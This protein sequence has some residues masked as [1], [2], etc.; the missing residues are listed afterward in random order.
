[1]FPAINSKAPSAGIGILKPRCPVSS[2]MSLIFTLI[3]LVE[4]L[5]R[6][7]LRTTVVVLAGQVYT[8]MKEFALALLPF[9]ILFLNVLGIF[10]PTSS[11]KAQT[12]TSA[13]DADEIACISATV[14]LGN[15]A[16]NDSFGPMETASARDDD[17]VPASKQT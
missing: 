3:W 11:N 6:L 1:M 4:M 10:Y 12:I 5:Q 13:V 8:V 9:L 2:P 16:I 7:M 17:A 14:Q 15:L